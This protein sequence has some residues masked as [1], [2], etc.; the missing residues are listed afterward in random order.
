MNL[1]LAH[2]HQIIF[3]LYLVLS[4]VTEIKDTLIP[5]ETHGYIIQLCMG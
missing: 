5:I 3:C 1:I 2:E 4:L